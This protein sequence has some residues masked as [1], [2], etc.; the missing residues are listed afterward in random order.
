[1][2]MVSSPPQRAA[3]AAC[4]CHERHQELKCPRGLESTVREVPVEERGD[5]EHADDIESGR[6]RDRDPTHA[7]PD[8]AKAQDVVKEE[9]QI[10]EPFNSF[11]SCSVV[12]PGGGAVE[13]LSDE[14]RQPSLK[15]SGR[16]HKSIIQ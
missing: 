14:Y 4:T 5:K 9:W 2:A 7:D 3:L 8:H 15:S 10:P 11:G 12:T 13:P 16:A 1:M 6:D